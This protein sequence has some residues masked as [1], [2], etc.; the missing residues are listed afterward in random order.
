MNRRASTSVFLFALV[1]LLPLWLS[2]C[3]TKPNAQRSSELTLAQFH[4]V[5]V[6]TRLNDNHA[7]DATI[8]AELRRRGFIA[9]HGHLTMMPEG[10]EVLITY[11]ARW[12]WDFR[13]YLIE[14]HLSANTAKTHKPI[15][16]GHLR[17]LGLRPKPPDALIARL[18]DQFLE[19]NV[20]K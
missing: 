17:Q 18:L 6:E 1:A 8:A 12:T 13:S 15:A 14:L 10:T 5:Y 9:T 11:D 2:G 19:K 4:R 20:S 3:A 7:I 16:T